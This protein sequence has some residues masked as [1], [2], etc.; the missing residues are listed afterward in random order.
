MPEMDGYEA[1]RCI[2]EMDGEVAKIPI[3]AMTANVM[4]GDK[5]KCFAAGMDDFIA[6]PIKF[7][8]VY[9]ILLKYAGHKAEKT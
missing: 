7:A 1:T 5:E 6:K 2:R 9:D 3:V 4:A 8:Q